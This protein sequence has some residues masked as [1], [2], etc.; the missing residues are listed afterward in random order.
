MASSDNNDD[1]NNKQKSKDKGKDKSKAEGQR[2]KR[3]HP[4]RKSKDKSLR[5][6]FGLAFRKHE[7]LTPLLDEL[8]RVA[9]PED[10]LRLSPPDNL[11]VTLTF[12]GAIAAEQLDEAKA[13]GSMVCSK[14]AAM[15][16]SCRGTGAFKNSLWVG[17]D[18]QDAL[19]ALA[20]DFKHAGILLGVAADPRA[21]QPHITVARFAPSAKQRLQPVIEKYRD[22]HWLDFRAEKAYLYL[23][24]T[25]QEGA[26]YSVLKSFPLGGG[27]LIDDASVA[28][29]TS[30]EE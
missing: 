19:L 10:K 24:E 16:L 3:F 6:F 26:R 2:R 5:C 30:T 29:G 21:Y 25:R 12:L 22:Q 13:L 17:I 7:V 20:D 27:E 28:E 15:D 11:H 23:S 9:L 14:H 1:Q 8:A 18:T 4:A